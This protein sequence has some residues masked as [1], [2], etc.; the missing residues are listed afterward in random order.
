MEHEYSVMT[1]R[2]VYEVS[3]LHVLVDSIAKY[4]AYIRDAF[5]Y[6]RSGTLKNVI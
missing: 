1:R 5:K 3:F 4:R 6:Y 2:L